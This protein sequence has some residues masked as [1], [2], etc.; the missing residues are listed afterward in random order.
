MKKIAVYLSVF[1]LVGCAATHTA[2]YKR[3]LAVQTRLSPTLFLDPSENMKTVFVQIKNTSGDPYF[4]LEPSLRALLE[5]RG[6]TVVSHPKKAHYCLQGNVLHVSKMNERQAR[7]WL[8]EG[9]GGVMLGATA[10]A[11]AA[12]DNQAAAGA[13]IGGAVGLIA[14]SLVEDI[15]YA[16]VADL[17]ISE[18]TPSVVTEKRK[19]RLGPEKRRDL[20]DTEQSATTITQDH[21][22]RHQTRI[23]STVNKMNLEHKEAAPVLREEVLLA[24]AGVM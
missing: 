9:F 21:W 6:F 19:Y 12:G 1:L 11:L 13:L 15:M 24:I 22:R 17:Q 8:D 20:A 5:E 16:V 4:C 18:R 10:G 7:S 2:I 23:V 14:N 3:H